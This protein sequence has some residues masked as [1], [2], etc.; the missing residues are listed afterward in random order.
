MSVLLAEKILQMFLII[1]AGFVLTKTHVIRP[2]DSE[3]IS[4]IVLFL[5]VP[6]CIISTFRISLTREILY[7]MGFSTI[8]SVGVMLLLILISRV[9][10]TAFRLTTVEKASVA[11]SNAGNLIIPLV[12]Y[13]FG[14]EWLVYC[15][16]FFGVQLVFMWTHMAPA[17]AHRKIPA[18]KIL[19]NPNIL[20]LIIGLGLMFFA[21]PLPSV[22]DTTITVLGDL[23]GPLAMLLIG[24]T[25][26]GTDFKKVFSDGRVYL[27]VVLR[28]V[29]CPVI[30][31]LIF[32]LLRLHTIVPAGKE[33]TTI[34]LLAVAAPSAAS[35]LQFALLYGEDREQAGAVNVMSTLL[36]I[37]TIPAMTELYL[38]IIG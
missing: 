11:Y 29:L 1:L 4:N 7:N 35:V 10:G 21:V 27:T 32:G 38:H 9:A 23:L 34:M 12:L 36:C 31:I 14:R 37:I 33:L 6:A 17:F 13:V 25:M 15:A 8:A 28:L 19:L 30:Y 20:S 2:K 24:I 3:P 16:V 18:G 26:A 22:V 5:I